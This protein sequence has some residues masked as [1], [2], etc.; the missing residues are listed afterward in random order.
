MSPLK[1]PLN[2]GDQLDRYRL[3]GI[4]A[5]SNVATIFRAR[6]LRHERDVAIKIPHPEVESD[7]TFA[8]WFRREQETSELLDHSGVMKVIT[9]P[10]RTAAYIVMEWFEGKPLRRILDD[11]KRLAPE[12]AI[13]IAIAICGALEYIH[14]RGIIHGDLRPENVLIGDGDGIKLIEFSGAAKT[15]ARRLTLTRIAQIT[16]S[17]DYIS[18]EELLGKRVDARSDLYSLGMILYEMLTGKQPFPQKDPS[19]R[20]LNYP[21]P[22]RE[23]DLAISP[24]LQEVIYRAME[25]NPQKRY[26]SAGEFARDLEHLDQVG[27]ADRPELRDWKKRRSSR[28]RRVLLYVAVAL[29]P[30]VIFGLL[31]YFARQ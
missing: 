9:D 21:V 3:D 13:R 23:I 29:I 2:S 11:E 12:R 5:Q 19:D 4:V 10:D 22:P 7:P 1:S 27:V 14:A 28:L 8:D 25:R 16:G 24:Q 15:K 17:S 20:L 26:A 30:I 6:D 31:L 18:P